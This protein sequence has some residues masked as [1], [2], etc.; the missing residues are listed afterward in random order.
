MKASGPPPSSDVPRSG[1]AFLAPVMAR[2]YRL[3]MFSN[4]GIFAESLG[5]VV[6][7]AC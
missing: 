5:A 3:P 4:P 7:G 1:G 2:R 6:A